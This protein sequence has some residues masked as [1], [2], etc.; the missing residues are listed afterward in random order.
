MARRDQDRRVQVVRVDRLLLDQENH[1]VAPSKDQRSA[2]RAVVEHQGAKLLELA[3][4]IILNGLSPIDL[5]LVMPAKGQKGQY[6]VLEGNRRLTA[7]RVLD[8][9]EL[10][11]G[12]WP[13]TGPTS[14]KKLVSYSKRYHAAPISEIPCVVIESRDAAKLWVDRRH[15]TDQ[16]GRG[17]EL[18]D[19]LG[20]SRA[21]AAEGRERRW[22]KARAFIEEA[23]PLDPELARWVEKRST[24][25]DR[26]LTGRA[27]REV[28]GVEMGGA[29]PEFA[30]CTPDQGREVL[31]GIFRLVT[32]KKAGAVD[33]FKSTDQI[34]AELAALVPLLTQPPT[35]Q[36]S[37]LAPHHP[38]R[39]PS[40]LGVGPRCPRGRVL[41]EV[42]QS[43]RCRHRMSVLAD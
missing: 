22:R 38:H 9:P 18:W 3:H 5:L 35:V 23:G 41:L 16:G 4:D 17:L 20:Q 6:T 28:L 19:A 25:L 12:A 42:K 32:D 34:R 33:R 39:S 29:R 26:I 31:L 2:V 43:S 27:V 21:D 1:R 37:T 14:Q 7:L 24:T 11:D 30:N 40:G 8:T 13:R 15:R 36:T 10:A